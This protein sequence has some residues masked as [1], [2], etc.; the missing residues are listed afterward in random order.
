MLTQIF[1][2]NMKHKLPFIALL[3]GLFAISCDEIPPEI[4]PFQ[5]PSGDQKIILEEFSG[6][7]CPNCPQGSA[8]IENLKALYGDRFIALTMHAFVTGGL[9]APH[10]DSRFDFRLDAAEEIIKFIGLPQGIPAASI[11]RID[12]VE[13]GIMLLPNQWAAKVGEVLNRDAPVGL[14]LVP[15]FD[16]LSRELTIEVT[17]LGQTLVNG[18]LRFHMGLSEDNIIDKQTDGSRIIEEYNHKHILRA[19]ITNNLGDNIASVL[20]PNQ[21]WTRTY[22]YTIPEAQG[23][24]KVKDMHVFAFVSNITDGA[25]EVIQAEEVSLIQ[26]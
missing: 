24:W 17:V 21:R 14:S 26:N 11:N 13:D 16:S 20:N 22:T 9:S 25:K 7:Q 18:D 6:V 3:L 10:S 8:Q 5:P 2:E 15:S 1:K 23:W 19:Y 12:F 4:P